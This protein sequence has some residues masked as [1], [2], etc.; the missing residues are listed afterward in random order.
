MLIFNDILFIEVPRTGTDT[1][2]R[3]VG[4]GCV[5]DGVDR[6]ISL[7]EYL[8]ARPNHSEMKR[9]AFVRNP[10]DR[11][12]SLYEHT[13][14]F[15]PKEKETHNFENFVNWFVSDSKRELTRDDIRKNQFDLLSFCGLIN[16]DFIGRFENYRSDVSK[17]L[18]TDVFAPTTNKFKH[19]NY[20]T[21]YNETTKGI[22]E[23]YVKKDLEH[24][25]YTF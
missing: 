24:F 15:H 7:S 14:A 19:R 16:I 4:D 21:Y 1:I 22:I 3:M 8:E 5:V 17:L 6:H 13:K 25:N 23:E 20:R 10:F 12:A 18:N 9:A 2:R 11:V